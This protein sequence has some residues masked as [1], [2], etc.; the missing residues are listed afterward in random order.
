[1][2]QKG[3]RSRWMILKAAIEKYHTHDGVIDQSQV[4]VI[5]NQ[6]QRMIIEAPAGYGKT[7]TMISRIAYLVVSNQIPNTKK[8]LSLT[9]S[10]NAAYKIRR[11]II[12][13]V[14]ELFDDKIAFSLIKD[15]VETS[16]YHKFCRRVL[17]LYG[18]LLN[19]NLRNINQFRMVDETD[20]INE[21]SVSTA[22]KGFLSKYSGAV[23]SIG[24]PDYNVDKLKS[25]LENRKSTYSRI[26]LEKF[27]PNDYITYNGVL[28]LTLSLFEEYPQIQE[29]Y[30]AF[31]PIVFV[32]EFQDTNWLQ[33][34][35]L[36][37][38]VGTDLIS[39]RN[40]HL[41]LFGDRLQRIYGFI[42]ALPEIFNTAQTTYNMELLK[43][44]TNHRFAVDSKLGMIDRVIRANAEN[45]GAPIIPFTVAA[46]IPILSNTTQIET[47]KDVLA[48]TKSILLEHQ[49]ATL[50][51][52]VRAGLKKSRTTEGIYRT[53]HNAG[54]DFF[55]A[56][57][58]DEDQ[59]YVT[60]HKDCLNIWLRI[61]QNTEIRSLKMAQNCLHREVAKL[62]NTEI[63]SSLKILLSLLLEK[64]QNDYFFLS[65]TEKTSII[66]E[67]LAN[68][69]L[70]QHLDLV[71]NSRVFLATSFAAKGL[72]WDYVILPDMQKF[73]FPT[74]GICN[75]CSSCG[76]GWGKRSLQFEKK[77]LEELSVFYVATTRA[78]RD[79]FFL[80]SNSVIHN[81]GTTA[82]SCLSCL[83]QLPGLAPMQQK[84]EKEEN[85]LT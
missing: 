79:I 13:Q 39:S 67:V 43:L 25:K 78:K 61:L 17:A 71:K 27:V 76:K 82:Q 32:D 70:K 37:A 54:V 4:D 52:L 60:F 34:K 62:H 44:N 19:D 53:L 20:N 63:T 55:F 47:S 30:H 40:R 74:K 24:K 73:T 15:R 80:S 72:E 26:L 1:M 58:S 35:I 48:I 50:A 23:K 49:D 14:K 46:E 12:N 41:Y 31:F 5:L 66:S 21:I 64:V 29:F 28:L 6:A 22:E 9:F 51:I 56:L 69:A 3:K 68:R 36:Q 38:I 18:Y 42:G 81:D 83:V 33:W 10:V 75:S 2:K 84:K 11:D 57:Y 45:L 7:K 85:G 59:E 16:N 8:I 65:F 77:F